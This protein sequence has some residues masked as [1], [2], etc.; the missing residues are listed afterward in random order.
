MRRA[1]TSLRE[2]QEG[3]TLPELL[4]TMSVMAIVAS[5]VMAVALQAFTDTGVI[6]NRRDVFG[7]GRIAL[8]RLSKQL[9]QAESIDT[10]NSTASTITYSS[11]VNGTP[12]TFVWRTSGSAA[13][14]SLQESRDGGAH[15]NTDLT[16]LTSPSLFTYTAHG[17]VTDEVTIQL[18]LG[19]DTSST[20]VSIDVY[21]R[22]AQ[23]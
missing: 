13:P 2:R 22:N 7:D 18:P 4:V 3:F 9:R 8:D 19:T 17:G 6:T 15:F 14:Y 23:T 20:V 10:G 5:A 1:I 12:T 11:Y 16:A 21:L